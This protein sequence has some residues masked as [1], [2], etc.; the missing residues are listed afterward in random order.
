MAEVSVKEITQIVLD[1]TRKTRKYA[2]LINF[3]VALKIQSLNF[4]IKR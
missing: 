3:M 2:K 4:K 1:P